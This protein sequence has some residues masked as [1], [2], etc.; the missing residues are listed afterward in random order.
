MKRREALSISLAAAGGLFF[1]GS[2][3]QSCD[4]PP[5]PYT[6]FTY[7]DM[8]IL[9]D[10]S[11]I[12]IP[13][14]PGSPGARAANT[15]DFVQHYI[16]DCMSAAYQEMVLSGYAS[17]KQ[18]CVD[19]WGRPFH[20]LTVEKKTEVVAQLIQEAQ[21]MAGSATPHFFDTLR[22]LILRGYF[23]SETGMTQCLRYVP[24]P[25]Y[26]KGIIP[27]RTGEKSWAL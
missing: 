23:T 3:V 21:E 6:L 17:F 26:Q 14:T 10:L 1:G 12:L 9:N 20:K 4:R 19:K 13:D 24:V 27:Y 5:Y 8:D 15:G 22:S 11:D 7:E 2:L 18:T 25:G 16:T